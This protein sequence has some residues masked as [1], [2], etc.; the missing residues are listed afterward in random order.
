VQFEPPIVSAGIDLLLISARSE[1]PGRSETL[2]PEVMQAVERASGWHAWKWG[3]RLWEARAELALV[4]H[5]WNEALIAAGHVVEQSRARLRPKYEALG[6]LARARAATQL[7]LP[8]AAKDARGATEVARRLGD[9]A[10]L[11]DC[12]AV[13][14]EVDGS[15]ALL[16]EA[17]QGPSRLYSR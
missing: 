14:L 17:R 3:L 8:R 15:D 2:L 9:P 6:L 11:L 1:D 12:L 16:A 7:G 10:L 4:R 5:S 13:L